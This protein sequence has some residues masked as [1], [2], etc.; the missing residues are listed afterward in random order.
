MSIDALAHVLIRL[1]ACLM[2][3]WCIEPVLNIGGHGWHYFLLEDA[4]RKGE[5][6]AVGL[7]LMIFAIYVITAIVLLLRTQQLV[8]A[9]TA[10]LPESH[11]ATGV[12]AIGLRSVGFSIVGAAFI[13][14]GLTGVVHGA[15]QWH[16]TQRLGH[17]HSYPE[18]AFDLPAFIAA[19]VE[20]LLGLALL[21]GSG[22]VIRLLSGAGQGRGAGGV[23]QD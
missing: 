8:R 16:Y 2:L 19:V 13:V 18:M 23:A 5:L 1:F 12:D 9:V 15:V 3:V 17:L 6:A 21:H 20:T 22:R 11:G 4:D 10:G 7:S 14:H